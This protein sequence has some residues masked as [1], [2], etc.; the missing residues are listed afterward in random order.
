MTA[1]QEADFSAIE[2]H[3]LA[4][5]DP[6]L[7]RALNTLD[8]AT[9]RPVDLYRV[10]AATL[11]RCAEADVTPQQ[12]DYAKKI[13]TAEMYGGGLSPEQRNKQASAEQS[14]AYATNTQTQAAWWSQ[15]NS[16][17]WRK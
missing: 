13:M 16:E 2:A 10:R 15:F 14:R 6:R 3:A 5:I 9:G 1:P 4:A 8:A 12:R 11:F 17:R 7:A